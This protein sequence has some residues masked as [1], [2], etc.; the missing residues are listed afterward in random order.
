MVLGLGGSSPDHPGCRQ[1][2]RSP[3]S[4]VQALRALERYPARGTEH[5]EPPTRDRSKVDRSPGLR[6]EPALPQTEWRSAFGTMKTGG[7]H[8]QDPAPGHG[9]GPLELHVSLSAAYNLVRVRN[10]LE[11]TWLMI[12]KDLPAATPNRFV[13]GMV[14]PSPCSA[15]LPSE[16][17]RQTPDH[18]LRSLLRR[19]GC[20]S[21][22]RRSY[23]WSYAPDL[24]L[25]WPRTRGSE[26]QFLRKHIDPVDS[27]QV[28]DVL[29]GTYPGRVVR[30]ESV[31]ELEVMQ[32]TVKSSKLV[33]ELHAPT[34][35]L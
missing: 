7:R 2:L 13:P 6:G 9:S 19:T 25:Q 10:L 15:R 23:S 20:H 35:C 18:F 24:P 1:G 5:D 3:S 11:P 8:A 26:A 17:S 33:V 21:R 30:F 27:K 34:P 22:S 28:I 16:A 14:D 4:F 31:S 12:P 32:V 29:L